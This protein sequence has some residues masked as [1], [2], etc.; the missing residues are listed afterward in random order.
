MR[1][2]SA[3]N[4]STPY[5]YRRLQKR[6]RPVDSIQ[7]LLWPATAWRNA[8]SRSVLH[9]WILGCR[10]TTLT[11]TSCL[12]RVKLIPWTRVRQ[13]LPLMSTVGVLLPGFE[14]S[15][16]DSEGN[17]VP[18]RQCGEILLKGPSVMS[19]YFQDDESNSCCPEQGWLAGYG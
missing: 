8:C 13:M 12:R 14:M 6:W 4:R 15:I 5:L 3:R 7:K 11:R 16:Q 17:E 19:G 10:L 18:E 1:P 2:V 9:R